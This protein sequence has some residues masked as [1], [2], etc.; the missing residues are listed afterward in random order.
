LRRGAVVIATYG[1]PEITPR[2]S[3]VPD[4]GHRAI[5]KRVEFGP[6]ILGFGQPA[7]VPA[8]GLRLTLDLVHIR[9]EAA[10]PHISNCLLAARVL[11]GRV[12]LPAALVCGTVHEPPH[13]LVPRHES[14][15]LV[16]RVAHEQRRGHVVG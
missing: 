8:S 14:G 1:E 4:S 13:V 2:M 9:A 16:G 7:E 12:V 3:P 11:A 10:L 6:E 5:T 15:D